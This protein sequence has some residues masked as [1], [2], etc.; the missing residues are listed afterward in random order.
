MRHS[1]IVGW[2]FVAGC[3]VF[4]RSDCERLCDYYIDCRP[5]QYEDLGLEC[6]WTD[7]D[8]DARK[9]CV[10][11]CKDSYKTLDGGEKDDVRACIRCI[12]DD[13]DGDC[14]FSA[15]IDA[16]DDCS[17]ECSDNDAVDFFADFA[18]DWDPDFECDSPLG[19][20]GRGPSPAN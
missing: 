3:G 6:E 16:I 4:S 1:W 15:Y 8:K 11:A 10:D 20:I 19:P 12:E 2:V 17:D 5:E 14:D 13:T 7:G 9:E 18:D